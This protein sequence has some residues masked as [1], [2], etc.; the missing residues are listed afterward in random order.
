MQTLQSFI[1][2]AFFPLSFLPLFLGYFLLSITLLYSV[3]SFHLF[4]NNS[5]VSSIL[6]PYIPLPFHF[7][8]MPIL[9]H[10]FSYFDSIIS[11]PLNPYYL[12]LYLF[13]LYFAFQGSLCNLF[14]ISSSTPLVLFILSF[15]SS[16][17][18]ALSL[19]SVII[20]CHPLQ[21]P[22][23]FRPALFFLIPCF[24]PFF[25]FHRYN[26]PLYFSPFLLQ[27]C[28]CYKFPFLL[29]HPLAPCFWI[30]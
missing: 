7:T 13:F 23:P 1:F 8:L 26:P 28:L 27:T 3:P 18:A 15:P 21:A 9:F 30:F 22:F 20:F 29:I 11:S 17:S 6:S 10:P 4:I 24:T 2:F 12:N 16:S 19:H 14:F 5:F 25:L